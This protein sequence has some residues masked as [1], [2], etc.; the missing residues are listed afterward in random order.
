[1]KYEDYTDSQ[2]MDMICESSEEAKDILYSKYKYII[3]IAVKKYMKMANMLGIDYND[4]YQEALVGFADSLN[5]YHEDKDTQLKT[6]I[7]VCVERR[8]QVCIIKAGRIKNKVLNDSLSLEHTYDSFKLPLK[9]MLSDNNENNP[10]E[11]ITKEEGLKELITKI[12]EVLSDSEYEVYS[13]LISG[14]NYKEIATLLDKEPKQID[15]TI[16]RIKNKVKKILENR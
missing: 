11:N 1:M 16:Q 7:T 12:K 14:L 4:L 13:L 9:D 10:L 15:N 3:D 8:L 5:S 6:F 2:L